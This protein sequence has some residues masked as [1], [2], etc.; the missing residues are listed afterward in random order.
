MELEEAINQIGHKYPVFP[1][2]LS[3]VEERI[4][5]ELELNLKINPDPL[6]KNKDN[7][8]TA[9]LKTKIAKEDYK[10]QN[11]SE[12]EKKIVSSIKFKKSFESLSKIKSSDSQENEDILSEESDDES[13]VK[14][15]EDRKLSDK[16]EVE[17]LS[18]ESDD[19]SEVKETEGR[20]D[21]FSKV[22]YSFNP[23]FLTP[24]IYGALSH[25]NDYL[26]LP[27]KTISS[28]SPDEDYVTGAIAETIKSEI[29]ETPEA[30]EKMKK[31]EYAFL[32]G[33]RTEINSE[34]LRVMN[35][36]IMQNSAYFQLFEKNTLTRDVNY[37]GY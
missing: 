26:K 10:K 22:D 31:M 17:I 37:R 20:K 34:D 29:L 13:E 7:S 25:A 12:N 3:V 5:E 36:W 2:A 11:I 8:V 18:E 28:G 15:S 32:L 4:K 1:M 27:E 23:D 19:E 33:R 30:E 35:L 6:I 14:E 16:Q 21:R 9:K 24:V